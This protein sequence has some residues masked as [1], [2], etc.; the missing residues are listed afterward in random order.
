MF[1]LKIGPSY[2]PQLDMKG[3]VAGAPPSQFQAIYAF[4]TTSPYRY[5]LFMAAGGFN[6]AYGNREAPLP[7]IL[8][9][10]A[11]KLLPVLS[12][13]CSDHIASVID[14]YTLSEMVKADPFKVP[15]WHNLLVENDPGSFTEP[16]TVPL[17]IIQGGADEQI[18]P[19][20]TQALA[21]HLCSIG[22]TVQRWI[23]PGQSHAGVI[24]PSFNDMIHWISDRFANESAPD[25]YAPTGLPAVQT[26]SC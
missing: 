12:Q 22:Q 6:A 17:L 18:P 3:V 9:A 16:S 23:Y 25:P 19:I 11:M 7:Q 1:A 14:K 21:Q 15:K 26:S 5:Y 2:A 10:K 4:L 8:T 13:G 20:T 24:A